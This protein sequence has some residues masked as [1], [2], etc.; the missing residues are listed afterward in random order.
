MGQLIN[1]SRCHF[2]HLL[3]MRDLSFYVRLH[4]CKIADCDAASPLVFVM[5]DVI[6][7]AYE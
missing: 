6:R 4:K 2:F 3:N 1:L 7:Y 5:L